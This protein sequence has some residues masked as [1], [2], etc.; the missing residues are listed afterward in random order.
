[1]WECISEKQ[2]NKSIFTVKICYGEFEDYH[3]HIYGY[4][5]TKLEAKTF[6]D[7][8][9][10]YRK[11][12]LIIMDESDTYHSEFIQTI[13]KEKYIPRIERPKWKAGIHQ[14]DITPEMRKERDEINAQNEK[15]SSM[16]WK[17]DQ[18][19]SKILDDGMAVWLENRTK[20]LTP[21]EKKF[22]YR[23]KDGDNYDL[24]HAIFKYEELKEL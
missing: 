13:Q 17:E 19:F 20:T 7:R 5:T 12:A 18:R 6:I 1:M 21:E 2:K 8:Y 15:I 4:V 16:N 11:I 23:W 3:E 24:K 9:D 22:V 10:G 14:K